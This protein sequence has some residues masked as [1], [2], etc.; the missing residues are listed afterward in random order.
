MRWR[1]G[2]W[3]W[4]SGVKVPFQPWDE[5]ILWFGGI[6]FHLHPIFYSNSE[7]KRKK[8]I[9]RCTSPAMQTWLLGKGMWSLKVFKNIS[10][11]G[12][13][14]LLK[15]IT[16]CHFTFQKDILRDSLSFMSINSLFFCVWLFSYYIAFENLWNRGPRVDKAQSQLFNQLEFP[17]FTF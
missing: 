9:K 3:C 12:S 5:M 10:T 7:L 1:I 14:I 6:W 17:K 8:Y 15:E 2:I 4:T 13:Q 11:F 16:P